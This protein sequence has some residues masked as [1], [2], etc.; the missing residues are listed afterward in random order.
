ME[1]EEVFIHDVLLA[2]ASLFNQ[3][4]SNHDGEARKGERR[5]RKKVFQ[6]SRKPSATS[7]PNPNL[8]TQ[9]PQKQ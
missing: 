4:A 6:S 8:V 7:R 9:G 3:K 5:R 1:V 2:R